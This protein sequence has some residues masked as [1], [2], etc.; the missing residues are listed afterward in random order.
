M[1]RKLK[2]ELKLTKLRKQQKNLVEEALVSVVQRT[3]QLE[4]K[5]LLIVDVL[6]LGGVPVELWHLGRSIGG[7][8][9][10]DETY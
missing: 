7:A 8:I 3:D 5:R 6:N 1:I 9:R 4:Q 10:D 2:S